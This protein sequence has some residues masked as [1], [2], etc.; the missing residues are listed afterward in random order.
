MRHKVLERG[1]ATRQETISP[2][3]KPAGLGGQSQ[4]EDT[5]F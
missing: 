4:P 3:E 5:G 1:Q 2:E